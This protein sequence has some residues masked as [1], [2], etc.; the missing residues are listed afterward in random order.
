[1]AVEVKFEGMDELIKA[2]ETLGQKGSRIENEALKEAGEYLAEE[3][4]KEAP[5]R[6]GELRDSIKCSN[7][8]TK[9]GQKYV[10]VGPDET[11]NWR[12][13]FIEFGTVKM[14]ANPFMSRAYE[15]NKEQV[16]EIIAQKLREGLGL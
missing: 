13:K 4:K 14:R 9:Q 5:V 1:M 2:V 3:M 12:A 6:S 15:K 11:T 8:K 7:V 16:R 10:E